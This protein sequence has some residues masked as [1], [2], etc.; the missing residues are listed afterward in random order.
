MHK[1]TEDMWIE[2]V[3]HFGEHAQAPLYVPLTAISR[4]RAIKLALTLGLMVYTEG[5]SYVFTAKKEIA[6]KQLKEADSLH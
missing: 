5:S 3:K 2:K 6:E 4:A 1:H